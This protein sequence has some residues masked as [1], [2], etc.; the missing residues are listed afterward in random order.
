MTTASVAALTAKLKNPHEC[1]KLLS[2]GNGAICNLTASDKGAVEFLWCKIM[3]LGEADRK[4]AVALFAD[5]IRQMD[6]EALIHF[7]WRALNDELP[8]D[9][10][11][12][13]FKLFPPV[14]IDPYIVRLLGVGS[15]S[16]VLDTASRIL[17]ENQLLSQYLSNLGWRLQDSPNDEAVQDEIRRFE[18]V[19]ALSVMNDRF[20]TPRPPNGEP[21]FFFDGHLIKG[22]E[23]PSRIDDPKGVYVNERSIVMEC[24]YMAASLVERCFNQYII[25]SYSMPV[26]CCQYVEQAS[27]R[28]DAITAE[29]VETWN[30]ILVR[31]DNEGALWPLTIADVEVKVT[32]LGKGED[33]TGIVGLRFRAKESYPG[34][35]GQILFAFWDGLVAK[36]FDLDPNGLID[37]GE[38][39][40]LPRTLGL[41]LN[42][43]LVL[44]LESYVFA[45]GKAREKAGVVD[46]NVK[47]G[48][49]TAHWVRQHGRHV[50]EPSEEAKRAARDAGFVLM[51]G[52]TFVH[53]HHRCKGEPPE[54]VT[55]I[56]RDIA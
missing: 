51:P 16:L 22:V 33:D 47:T 15:F 43:E 10:G 45:R 41:L 7:A 20:L 54:I 29:I 53:S 12:R 26:E 6:R 48:E 31:A 55:V 9:A 37:L 46:T 36:D 25:P 8:H 32:I 50:K 3:A 40:G 34:I 30:R 2:K 52:T 42:R 24:D 27:Y 21:L 28:E 39:E 17:E 18:T 35:S 5:K 11:G 1:L 14:A 4:R 49:R 44:A 38:V 23:I 13:F 56:R 19:L